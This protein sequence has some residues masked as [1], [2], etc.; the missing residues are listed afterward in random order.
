MM[1]ATTVV[2][3]CVTVTLIYLIF[4]SMS[5]TTEQVLNHLDWNFKLLAIYALTFVFIAAETSLNPIRFGDSVTFGMILMYFTAALYV[6]LLVLVQF[7]SLKSAV[8]W[9]T[10][11]FLVVLFLVDL[12]VV[13][14]R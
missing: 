7:D 13:A 12:I 14:T 1:V 8:W 10:F 5:T 9:T 6:V 4:Y 2:A 3:L 11:A